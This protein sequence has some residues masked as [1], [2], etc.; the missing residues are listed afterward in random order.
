MNLRS[1]LSL[2][3]VSRGGHSA[4][5]AKLELAVLEDMTPV[6]F[7]PSSEPGPPED[8]WGGDDMDDGFEVAERC[9]EDAAVVDEDESEDDV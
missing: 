4:A 1:F 5:S 9:H 6:P 8:D 7:T 3:R 2:L